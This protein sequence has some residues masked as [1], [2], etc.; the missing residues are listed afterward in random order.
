MSKRGQGIKSKAKSS[1]LTSKLKKNVV[2]NPNSSNSIKKQCLSASSAAFDNVQSNLNQQATKN[3][4]I[5]PQ[6]SISMQHEILTSKPKPVIADV[7]PTII[8]N[9]IKTV[10]FTTAP[11]VK[12]SP[13]V[14]NR[15]SIICTSREDKEKLIK[16]LHEEKIQFISY[17]EKTERPQSYVVKGIDKETK[18][19][20]IEADIKEAGLEP[21]KITRLGRLIEGRS[22][23]Y[24]IQFDRGIIDLRTLK[25]K[26]K[27][28]NYMTVSWEH[29]RRSPN[30]ITQCQRCQ[31]FGHSFRNCHREP[32]CNKCA[33]NHM[34]DQCTRTKN[35]PNIQPKCVN[36][37]EEHVANFRGCS[38]FNSAIKLK[39]A[40]ATKR[41][42]QRAPARFAPQI[43][44]A[45]FQ[46]SQEQKNQY[47]DEFPRLSTS[48]QPTVTQHQRN[49]KNSNVHQNYYDALSDLD[50]EEEEF[51][52]QPKLSERS[53]KVKVSDPR[54]P[55]NRA[56]MVPHSLEATLNNILKKLDDLTYTVSEI[57]KIKPTFEKVKAIIPQ[58]ETLS[59][60]TPHIIALC[61]NSCAKSTSEKR[62]RSS[63]RSISNKQSSRDHSLS[64]VEMETVSNTSYF[65]NKNRKNLNSNHSQSLPVD[66]YGN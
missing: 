51:E 23:P 19:D 32:R 60:L 42:Q 52:S 65:E 25:H 18:I 37:G 33:G 50:L 56:D 12:L 61:K 39:Q 21:L 30:L 20:E 2:Q 38:R 63:S 11:R 15:S 9:I 34:F 26:I 28:I 54:K 58:L 55:H 44:N 49:P 7:S 66:N 22:Q 36:C 48:R 3:V 5:N 64:S 46:P 31:K 14:D 40:K 8:R 47:D 27:A 1:Q 16:K 45:W 62:K 59:N 13:Y 35:D 41:Q 10:G 43:G 24:I 6:E 4:N 53:H 17:T 29:L 57:N